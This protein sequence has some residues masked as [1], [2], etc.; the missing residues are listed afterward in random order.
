MP[1]I[2]AGIDE[3]GYG[4]LLGPLVVGAVAFETPHQL[5]DDLPEIGDMLHPVVVAAPPIPHGSLVI[6]DSKIVHRLSNGL[7]HLETATVLGAVLSGGMACPGTLAAL[8]TAAGAPPACPLPWYRWDAAPVP[9]WA[10]EGAL[11]ITKS[12][13]Q[14][15]LSSRNLRIDLLQAYIID[16]GQFNRLVSNTRN[17]AAVLTS[18]VMRHLHFIAQRYINIDTW[19]IVDKNGGRDHY[20]D[21]LLRTFP[22]ARWKVACESAEL[23]RYQW[24]C[25]GRIL[26]IDFRQKAEQACAATAWASMVCKYFRERAMEQFNLWWSAALPVYIKPTAGYYTDAMRWLDQA[27]EHLHHSG[28]SRDDFVRLR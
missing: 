8:A 13:L 16:E 6:A 27:A 10:G 21:M 19:V 5:G 1:M 4:P 22:E 26:R 12:M 15:R 2:L 14:S 18:H 20:L 9:R 7:A 24:Q 28:F 3:A 17:K 23:S 11:G 25:D